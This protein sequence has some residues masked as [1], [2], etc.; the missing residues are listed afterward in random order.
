V[1]LAVA[2]LV[3]NAVGLAAALL[4]FLTLTIAFSF[5]ALAHFALQ[6]A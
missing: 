2:L 6:E 1:G 3:V 4:P 5:L